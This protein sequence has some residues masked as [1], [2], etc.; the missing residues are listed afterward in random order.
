M[1]YQRDDGSWY[2]AETDFQQWIDS[3][4]TGFNLQSISYFFEEGFADEFKAAFE[5]GVEFYRNNFF[6]ED[7]TPKYYHNKLYPID[8]H[9]PAQAVVFF[10]EREDTHTDLTKKIVQWMVNNLWSE[11]G[12]FYFQKKKLHT[13]KIPYVRWGQAWAFHALTEYV[14]N[15]KKGKF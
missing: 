1:K 13:N 15:A 14:F 4:H 3:F 12:F 8:I 2:Y 9:A 11:K 5:R 7:G 10:S 6:L